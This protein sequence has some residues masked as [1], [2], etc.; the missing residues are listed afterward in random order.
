MS[1]ILGVAALRNSGAALAKTELA[2]H[3]FRNPLHALKGRCIRHGHNQ[4][5][6]IVGRNIGGEV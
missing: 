4:Q 5:F 3:L 6:L 1:Q 2:P